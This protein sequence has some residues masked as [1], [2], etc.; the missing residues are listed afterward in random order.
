MTNL[1]RK[2]LRVWPGAVIV[3]LQLLLRFV[4]PAVY[5][6]ALLI[7]VMAV[8]A[9]GLLVV[10]WWLF[11]SRAAWSERLGAVGL[12]VVALLATRRMVDVS[13]ATGAMGM[14]F[15]I[16][17]IPTVSLALVAWAVATRRLPDRIRRVSMVATILLASG[18]WACIRTGGF[19]AS[20]FQSDLHWRW[21]KTPEER[22]LAQSGNAPGALPLAPEKP[23]VSQPANQPVAQP[24]AAPAPEKHLVARSASA[25]A[26]IPPAAAEVET[27]PD[28]PGFRGPHRDDILPGV[29][30][31]TDWTAS[32]PVALWRR[33][34]G[35]GW[36]S[37]AVRAGL[38]YTQEQRGPDEFV[39]CYK[40]ATG[41]PVWAH[42]DP[43]RFWESN[44][45]PGPRGTPT[46][47]HGRVYTFGATGILNVLNASDGAMVWSH[48][49][50]IDTGM[51][52]PQWGF[53]S[54]PLV[55]DDLVIVATAGQLVAYDIVTGARR[56]IGPAHGV[57]YSSPQLAA[58]GGVPQ[59]LLLSE[60]G[61]TSLALADGALLWEYPWIGYPIVQPA[62]TADGDVLISVSDQSGTRRLA[63]ARGPAGW[64]V[65]ERW[66]SRFLKPYFNDFVVHNGYA[67]GFDGSIL[68][69]IDLKDGARKWK[70]GRYGNGQLVLLADQDVLL[71]S[72]EEGELALVRATPDQFTELAHFPAIDGKTWNHP[73]LAG[74]TLLVRN[75]QEMA[76]FRLSLAP[77]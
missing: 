25:P 43:A 60:A 44:G 32:P 4:V 24:A 2:P 70:G 14:L 11:F 59:I 53:A 62:L 40:L 52:T 3:T 5:P 34:I 9:G 1:S 15:P 75:G 51:K 23:P 63:V 67:Y 46:L 29:R 22:L 10:L 64:T 27:G 8:P 74:D 31:K 38:I 12:I 49:A 36:S 69:C 41:E 66:T 50:A 35:P 68:A 6:G 57:S 71:V 13:I 58:I 55:A 65:A 37:F 19:T 30:I 77:R 76:A 42:R 21:T 33:P 61:L 39:A 7:G 72:T 18:L 16:L 45:G 56:W 47:S 28:W 20:S 26:V 48:N 54:S 73:V 17:S